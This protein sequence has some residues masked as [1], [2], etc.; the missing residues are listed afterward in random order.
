MTDLIPPKVQ[1]GDK[2]QCEARKAGAIV[3]KFSEGSIS[4]P[5]GR[6]VGCKKGRPG[7]IICGALVNELRTKS[8]SATAEKLGVTIMT[9]LKWQTQLGFITPK[10]RAARAIIRKQLYKVEKEFGGMLRQL[11]SVREIKPE[12]LECFTLY[13]TTIASAL[14]ILQFIKQQPNRHKDGIRKLREIIG[15]LKIQNK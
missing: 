12:N 2:I 14:D 13:K 1:V 11:N 7:M 6:M 4:W 3:T 5:M 9:V 10:P 8:A 15:K